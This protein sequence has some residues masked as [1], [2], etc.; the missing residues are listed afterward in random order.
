MLKK[1]FRRVP[2][3]AIIAQAGFCIALLATGWFGAGCASPVAAE[4]QPIKSVKIVTQR[5]GEATRFYVNNMEQT[6]VTVTFEL[7]MT[8]LKGNIPLPHTMTVP[9]NKMTEA[10]LVSPIK[11]AEHWNYTYTSHYTIGS[12]TAR[13]DDNYVYS[14]PY[15]AGDSFKVTQGYNGSYSHTGPDQ[16]AIDWKM[17]AGT[18]VHA[19]R[20]GVVA[21]VKDD[22]NTGGG[23][24]KFVN[25]ANYIL[26]R[27]ADGTMANYA[28]L[29]KG[30]S[31]VRVGQRVQAGDCIGMSGNT[32]FSSGPHLH[33][34]VF[35]TRDGMQR[36]SLPVKFRTGNGSGIT[37]A[38]GKTYKCI[39]SLEGPA[40]II[41]TVGTGLLNEKKGERTAQGSPTALSHPE[42][43]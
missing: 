27:H 20:D 7:D 19:A 18:P 31:R 39:H 2:A 16:Y 30:G 1:I 4:E 32:G 26:I 41:A 21:K 22:S 36:V 11:P 43:N 9:G 5:E 14:L 12:T 25:C 17:P 37:L 10:F 38:E 33:F 35:K 40:P 28:H 29:Q 34:S 42:A 3:S 8:N 24:R 23:D 15:A 6:D 13:H